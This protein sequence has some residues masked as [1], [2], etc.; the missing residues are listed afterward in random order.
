MF[1]AIERIER[2]ELE[3]RWERT[4][5]ML[6]ELLPEAKGLLSF[7]RVTNYWMT[8]H[9]PN[10]LF[11]LPLEGDPVLMCRKGA[12]R[13]RLESSVPNIVEFRSYRDVEGL[14]A[15]AGVPLGD[16]VAVEMNGIPWGFGQKLEQA[17]NDT[18]K[19]LPGDGVVAMARTKKTE[20]E[21]AKMRMCGERHHKALFELLPEVISPGMTERDFCHKA[22]EVFFSLGHSGP[23]RMGN[24]GEECF[25]GHVAAGDSANYPSVFNGPVGLR[26]EHPAVPFMGYAGKVWQPGEPMACDIGFGLEGYVTDKTQ[27]YWAGNEQSVPDEVRRGHDFCIEIQQ[28]IADNMV[29]GAIPE[30]LYIRCVEEAEKRGFA[31]GFMACGENKV[32]FI[33]HGIGLV[34]DEFPAIAKKIKMP[35]EEGMTFAL[36]P[37]YGIPGLGMVGVENTFEVTPD[38]AR[39]ITGDDYSMLCID[40]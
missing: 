26:G 21:L 33:G 17:L 8:G 22:W 9:L 19:L 11:W 24:F 18:R 14:A 3:L 36:E 1:T 34:V 29:P 5:A 20:W 13:A 16:A 31:E 30:E 38:G 10:G 39:C 35:L 27:V 32:A 23:L 7:A 12:E 40:A 2:S 15:E 6:A 37:K 25:L 28:W 4:R